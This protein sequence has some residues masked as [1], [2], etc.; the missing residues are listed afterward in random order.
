MA[1][2]LPT[3]PV[4]TRDVVTLAQR[5]G[6]FLGEGVGERVPPLLE[7]E[8]GSFL[9]PDRSKQLRIFFMGLSR[10]HRRDHGVALFSRLVRPPIQ[11]EQQRPGGA[12][13]VLNSWL[14]DP[15]S[16]A[17]CPR[18]SQTFQLSFKIGIL[19]LGVFRWPDSDGGQNRGQTHSQTKR[20]ASRT[21]LDSL[22][23]QSL[24][25]VR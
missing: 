1:S 15:R 2:A 18:T 7:G 17:T 13:E 14:F 3:A 19:Q 25:G 11:R 6:L 21:R 23:I 22:Q 8:P 4:L 20:R 5:L 9:T 12:S 16:S 10:L 24:S